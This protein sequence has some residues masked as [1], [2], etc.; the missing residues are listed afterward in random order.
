MG[1]DFELKPIKEENEISNQHFKVI[2]V[3][4]KSTQIT[5]KFITA[6]IF[7]NQYVTYTVNNMDLIITL[8]YEKKNWTR[9]YHK[10]I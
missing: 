9:K 3:I 8:N 2:I 10:I 7:P 5:Y 6:S 4:K 1:E